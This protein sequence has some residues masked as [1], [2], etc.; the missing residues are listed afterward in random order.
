MSGALVVSALRCRFRCL[1]HLESYAGRCWHPPSLFDGSF[2]PARYLPDL[3]IWDHEQP[4]QVRARCL[5][6]YTLHLG[7]IRATLTVLFLL[8]FH[9]RCRIHWHLFQVRDPGRPI[10]GRA[11]RLGLS[12]DVLSLKCKFQLPGF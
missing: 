6:A 12:L 1:H 3:P 10:P 2:G 7:C 9:F 4:V 11:A 5:L 8:W